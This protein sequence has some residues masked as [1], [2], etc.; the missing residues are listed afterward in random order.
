MLFSEYN[1]KI[2]L[3]SSSDVRYLFEKHIYDSIKYAVMVLL[4]F[5]TKDMGK[6][7]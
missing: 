4:Q 5:L 7:L 6:N 1:E 2:N 3:I